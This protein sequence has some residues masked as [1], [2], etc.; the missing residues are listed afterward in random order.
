MRLLMLLVMFLLMGAFF[1]V[2]N[3]E[4]HLANSGEFYSFGER[5]YGWFLDLGKNVAG[6]VGNV[7]KMDW[8][9]KSS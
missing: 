2:S 7:V 5:Y 6:L 4:F 3:N 1:I 9:P 8:M